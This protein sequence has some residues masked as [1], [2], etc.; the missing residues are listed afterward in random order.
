MTISSEAIAAAL[1]IAARN[2]VDRERTL[3][4]NDNLRSS[5]TSLGDLETRN[6]TLRGQI[7]AQNQLQ[8]IAAAQI[9]D[10]NKFEQE[11][12]EEAFKEARDEAKRLQAQNARVDSILTSTKE[13]LFSNRDAD[14]RQVLQGSGLGD[15]FTYLTLREGSKER[16]NLFN[17]QLRDPSLKDK[18]RTRIL[19]AIQEDEVAVARARQI[20]EGANGGADA[21]QEGLV[22]YEEMF[23]NDG[24]SFR[25][26]AS[27]VAGGLLKT[28]GG[29]TDLV[30][31]LA[32]GLNE[33][34][35]E[36]ISG[37]GQRV[38]AFGDDV[39]TDTVS[40]KLQQLQ[41]S[42]AYE[43]FAQAGEGDRVRTVDD[44]LNLAGSSLTGLTAGGVIQA[45]TDIV[46]LAVPGAG[47][48]RALN[49]GNRARSL[50]Q[51]ATNTQRRV[52][53]TI[54]NA[55]QGAITGSLA[56]G[57]NFSDTELTDEFGNPIQETAGERAT[58]AA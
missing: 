6:A 39:S 54:D 9:R 13:N 27:D 48:A 29:A 10:A 12:R 33:T 21:F 1:G 52:A 46:G 41:L 40:E 36:V 18:E 28:V 45:G 56:A 20:A 16:L 58:R 47:A 35:G 7:A 8:S 31:A 53:S 4:G 19:N 37:A 32:G 49:V 38:S 30:G 51:G 50:A 3:S 43:E 24:A 57:Q 23:A 34:A 11:L 26:I 17:N 44:Y 25:S 2:T 42:R 55:S 15:A 22:G 14:E 5:I